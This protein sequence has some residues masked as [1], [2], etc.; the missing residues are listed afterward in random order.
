[1]EKQNNSI[2]T[3]STKISLSGIETELSTLN[4]HLE[5]QNSIPRKFL[6]SI[7]TGLGTA[8]GATLVAGIVIYIILRIAEA[9]NILDFL[10]NAG[11][12]IQ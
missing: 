8:I 6:S 12:V 3:K 10:S 9:T 11:I 4:K 2:D 7:L 1:M 5:K